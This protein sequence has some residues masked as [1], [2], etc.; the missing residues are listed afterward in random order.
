MQIRPQKL[1]T[2]C[3]E[4]YIKC[5]ISPTL[6]TTYDL[7]NLLQQHSIL[8]KKNN[9]GWIMSIQAWKKNNSESNKQLKKCAAQ[10]CT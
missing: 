2:T 8:T 10:L 4:F 6:R 9:M 1:N 5:R 7:S 3:K